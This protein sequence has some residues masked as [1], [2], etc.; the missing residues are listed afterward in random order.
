M[1]K[2]TAETAAMLYLALLRLQDSDPGNCY[3]NY[4]S[5]EEENYVCMDCQAR[6][7]LT[8]ADGIERESKDIDEDDEPSSETDL[9]PQASA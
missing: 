2:I 5:D 3:C 4:G 7:A 6:K 8:A 9:A 1:L